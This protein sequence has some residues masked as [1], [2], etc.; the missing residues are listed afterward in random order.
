M[1][2]SF[3]GDTQNMLEVEVASNEIGTI[4]DLLVKIGGVKSN[5]E[6]RRLIDG[7]AIKIDDRL[8]DSY[9]DEIPERANGNFV[10][11]K[12]KKLHLKIKVK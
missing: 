5:S 12:G 10:F 4:L 9:F 8:V 6:A 7:R 1:K 3:A 11:H 2:A